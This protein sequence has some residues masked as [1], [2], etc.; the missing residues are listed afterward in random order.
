MS[1]RVKRDDSTNEIRE[2]LGFSANNTSLLLKTRSELDEFIVAIRKL[3]KHALTTDSHRLHTIKSLQDHYV[4]FEVG[5][6]LRVF[7]GD[8][9]AGLNSNTLFILPEA[10]DVKTTINIQTEYGNFPY[11]VLK[12]G[13]LSIF[14][15]GTFLQ[16]NFVTKDDVKKGIVHVITEK[17]VT[18]RYRMNDILSND[19][20]AR[21]HA[22][23]RDTYKCVPQWAVEAMLR[24]SRAIIISP[25]RDNEKKD[26]FMNKK[27][28]F[29]HVPGNMETIRNEIKKI[30][31]DVK[32]CRV[33]R[34]TD[35]IAH[36]RL[37]DNN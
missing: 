2:I 27:A 31:L 3:P 18:D 6:Q 7:I 16:Q 13:V 4:E 15:D 23:I 32:K 11:D 12:K 10:S 8:E 20:V 17:Y 14:K 35:F 37:F 33:L 30:K 26:A 21:T 28:E 29:A 34:Q 25:E 24:S 5:L 19:H 9:I 22:H 36:E 1:K